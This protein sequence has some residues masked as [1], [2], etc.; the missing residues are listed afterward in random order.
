MVSFPM[1]LSD[2]NY[3]E[4]PYFLQSRGL[5]YLRNGWWQLLQIW[6]WGCPLQISVYIWQ[7]SQTG[8]VSFHVA[9]FSYVSSFPYIRNCNRVV[10]LCKHD[11]LTVY[12][13][14]FSRN[15][16]C[17][18]KISNDPEIANNRT[19][20]IWPTYVGTFLYRPQIP[21]MFDTGRIKEGIMG[22]L[23]QQ[24]NEKN[25]YNNRDV[26]NHFAPGWGQRVILICMYM[27]MSV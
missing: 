12:A 24:A 1:I 7:T 8:V 17:D 10:C 19:W 27:Y 23:L 26:D 4:P 18:I 3:P 22:I 11:L 21:A 5:S 25:R 13:I 20:L 9:H 14:P 6:Y 15:Y 2:H 16:N